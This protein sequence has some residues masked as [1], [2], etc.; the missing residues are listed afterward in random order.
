MFPRSRRAFVQTTA[1]GFGYVAFAGLSTP[2]I[3]ATRPSAF[4]GNL[5]T[6]ALD[7]IAA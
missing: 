5:Y 6:A 3:T 4:G 7:R 1:S 2:V